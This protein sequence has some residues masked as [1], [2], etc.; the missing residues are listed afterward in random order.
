MKKIFVLDTNVILHDSNTVYSFADN[1]IVIPITVIEEIDA[2][3][4]GHD[5]IH[6]H[7]REFIRLLDSFPGDVLVNGGASLGKG[8]G[9]IS[10]LT[11]YTDAPEVMSAFIEQKT[12]HRIL[13][14]AIHLKKHNPA[15]TIVLVSKDVNM[16]LKAKCLGLNAQDYY[17]DKIK[18]IDK[19]YRGKRTIEPFPADLIDRLYKDPFEIDPG[20]AA[21]AD[22]VPNEYLILRN[23]GKSALAFYN[24]AAK[25]IERVDK[26]PAYGIMPRNA[27]QIFSLHAL[28]RPE[29]RLVTL[30]G[31][32]GT[33]KTLLALAGA[34][35]T[36][37]K[38]RQIY[39]ARPIVALS[40]KD[41]GFLPGDVASKVDPYMQPLYDN[42]G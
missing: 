31:K 33:G 22:L 17:S 8:M 6:Y 10:I 13:S 30:S 32:A 40:N 28:M 4:R 18:D 26:I 34:I 9:K 12:D 24:P 39:L 21:I 11:N 1:D 38:Y 41:L 42:L 25:K 2:F 7:A 37:K 35:E 29:A 23:E 36:R 15:G 19:L 14:A 16:R 5:L 27:E 3:K 20:D